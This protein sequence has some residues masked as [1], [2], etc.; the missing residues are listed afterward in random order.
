MPR[1]RYFRQLPRPLRQVA[2]RGGVRARVVVRRVAEGGGGRRE[3]V[4][5]RLAPEVEAGAAG[6]VAPRHRVERGDHQR[7]RPRWPRRA[8]A[9]ARLRA[10]VE[11]RSRERVARLVLGD[12]RLRARGLPHE[13]E[14]RRRRGARALEGD[15]RTHALLVPS[16]HQLALPRAAGGAGVVTPEKGDEVARQRVVQA[17]LITTVSASTPRDAP[18]ISASQS[19]AAESTLARP[20]PRH[21]GVAAE[22]LCKEDARHIGHAAAKGAVCG[23]PR[24]G[25]GARGG[26]QRRQRGR[27]GRRS[28]RASPSR[29][30]GQR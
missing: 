21:A 7:Q 16:E 14:A 6:K 9:G 4:E 22:R 25:V 19:G 8:R 3:R 26:A 23:R 5:V 20:G 1:I 30:G 18:T 27:R 24:R 11:A 28:C 10:S 15:E 12:E 29:R 17:R 2:A 13:R